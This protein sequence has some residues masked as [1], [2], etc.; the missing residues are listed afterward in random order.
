MTQDSGS[1]V[2]RRPKWPNRGSRPW[3]RLLTGR[4]GTA[5]DG[6]T[7]HFPPRPWPP[8]RDVTTRFTLLGVTAAKTAGGKGR[9]KGERDQGRALQRSICALKF[10]LGIAAVAT[11]ARCIEVSGLMGSWPRIHLPAF[12]RPLA[13]RYL[14]WCHWCDAAPSGYS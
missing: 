13:I 7:K 10:P 5:A 1:G 12:P 11:L 6:A 3:R 2:G 8:G 9:W 14:Q 4:R